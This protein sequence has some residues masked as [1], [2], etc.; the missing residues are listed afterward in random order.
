MKVKK[1]LTVT[2]ICI[3]T[4]AGL[5]ACS[6]KVVTVADIKESEEEKTEYIEMQEF[7]MKEVEKESGREE[8]KYCAVVIPEG[9][10]AS[11]EIP[12]MYLHEMAPLDSSNVYYSVAEG[13]AGIVSEKLTEQEYKES[14]EAAYKEAG[15]DVTVNVESFEEMDMNGVPAYKIR[16]AYETGDNRIEQLTYMILAENTYTITYSQSADDELLADF[17]VTDGEIKLVKEEEVQLAEAAE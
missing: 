14:L 12:G 4:V 11:E 1:L 17:E 13:D 6:K 2:V 16:S 9:Y 15:N 10:K 8:V 7:T 5:C 3:V